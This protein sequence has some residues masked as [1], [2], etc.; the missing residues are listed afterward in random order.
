MEG[1]SGED[2]SVFV[3]VPLWDMYTSKALATLGVPGLAA[4]LDSQRSS[5]V[6]A[7]PGTAEPGPPFH[8]ARGLGWVWR[9]DV[10]R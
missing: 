1:W 2:R 7:S 6:L 10:G 4:V 9:R 3:V 8:S 5:A